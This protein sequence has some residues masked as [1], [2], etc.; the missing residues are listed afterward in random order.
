MSLKER[1]K[2]DSLIFVLLGLGILIHFIVLLRFFSYFVRWFPS[3][4]YFII[5]FLTLSPYIVLI[6]YFRRKSAKALEEEVKYINQEF[7]L[8]LSFETMGF[9][10]LKA[11][12]AKLVPFRNLIRK[13]LLRAGI[14]RSHYIYLANMV[15]W[16]FVSFPIAFL[17]IKFFYDTMFVLLFNFPAQLSLFLS[18]LGAFITSMGVY[19]I[20]IIWPNYLAGRL[21]RDI[22]KNLVYITNFMSILASAGA[23][24]EEI[25]LALARVGEIYGIKPIAKAIVKS[26]QLLGKDIYTTLDEE[27]KRNPSRH[28]SELIQGFIS[29]VKSGGKPEEYLLTMSDKYIELRKRMLSKVIN[30]LNMAAEIYVAG[31]VALPVIFTTMMSIMGLLGGEVIAGLSAETM[32]ALMSYI[33]LPLTATAVIV[34]IDAVVSGA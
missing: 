6:R 27:S 18:L 21:K 11:P 29:S 5:P 9:K 15:F 8:P 30:Q 2:G 20:M 12:A 26:V 10:L 3:P 16:T 7:E 31:L 23:T 34:Y 13:N 14:Y 4:L 32:L 33:F 25:F 22:E 24:T 17:I 28:F 19:G 1:Q